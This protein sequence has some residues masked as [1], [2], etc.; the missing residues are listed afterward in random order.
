MRFR[1][2]ILHEFHGVKIFPWNDNLFKNNDRHRHEMYI[3]RDQYMYMHGHHS[4]AAKYADM[5]KKQQDI[6]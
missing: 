6:I 5:Q 1:T 4:A 3:K 2:L